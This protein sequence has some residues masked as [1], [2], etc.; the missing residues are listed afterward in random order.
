MKFI[1]GI[2]GFY[3][4]ILGSPAIYSCKYMLTYL[5]EHAFISI[6]CMFLL[7]YWYTG[8]WNNDTILVNRNWYFD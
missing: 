7:Q 1:S 6:V 8:F 4:E 3:T 2:L 5:H